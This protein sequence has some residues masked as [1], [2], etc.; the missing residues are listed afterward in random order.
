MP[1]WVRVNSVYCTEPHQDVSALMY[2]VYW[3][4]FTLSG[5]VISKALWKRRYSWTPQVQRCG[6]SCLMGLLWSLPWFSSAIMEKELCVSDQPWGTL[7]CHFK[8]LCSMILWLDTDNIDTNIKIDIEKY[9]EIERKV[10]VC[11]DEISSKPVYLGHWHHL[12]FTWYKFYSW[13]LLWFLSWLN[14]LSKHV[15]AY[16]EQT[17]TLKY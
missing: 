7:L 5:M 14:F 17:K 13:S 3:G 16:L 8:K 11:T 1:Q 15:L 12:L 6:C 10:N 4:F 2:W 9:T